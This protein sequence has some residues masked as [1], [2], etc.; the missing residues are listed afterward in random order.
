MALL[1]PEHR[2]TVLRYNLT[3]CTSAGH[4]TQNV[5]HGEVSE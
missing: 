4:I 5:M 1:L 3:A 2:D